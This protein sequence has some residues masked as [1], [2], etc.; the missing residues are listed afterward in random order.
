MADAADVAVETRRSEGRPPRVIVDHVDERGIDLVVMGRH[1]RAG[2]GERLLGSV[3]ER[4]LRGSDAPVLT[5]DGGDADDAGGYRN[6]L[7]PTDG[8]EIAERAAPYGVDVARRYGAT[9][10]LLN[11][12]DVQREGGLFSAGG[13]DAEFVERLEGR[14][15]ERVDRL[16]ERVRETDASAEPRTAVVRGAPHAG[17]REYVDANGVDLVV[18]SSEGE[19]N[20]AGQLLGS[21]ADRVLRTVDVPVLVV[22][23]P[24]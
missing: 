2:L 20:L 3:T 8:S 23:V 22:P 7:V 10:H 9:L 21:V 19:S 6:V 5:V 16:A 12:V 17:I 13:V 1:G 18:M 24:E 4:V 14:G 11:V 15:R